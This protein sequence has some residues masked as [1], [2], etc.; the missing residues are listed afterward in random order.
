MDKGDGCDD[1]WKEE[2]EGKESGEGSVVYREAPSNSL[3]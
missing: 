2:V 3:Y 1:E